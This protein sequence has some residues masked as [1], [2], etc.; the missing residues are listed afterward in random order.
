MNFGFLLYPGV[1]ELDFQGPWEIVGL[2]HKYAQGPRPV[3]LAATTAPVACAHGMRVLPDATLADAGPLR[4]LLVPGGF[5]AFELMKD[6]AT[7]DF[8]R[9]QAA[10]G[11]VLMSVCSGS[12][13][14]HAAGLLQGR[15]ASTNWKAVAMLREAGV[16]VDEERYTHDGPV[17]TSAG[18]SAGIDMLL[19]YIA[20][21]EGEATAAAVQLNAE[22]F[23]EGR[24]YCDPTSARPELPAYI[25]RLK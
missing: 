17:W 14:L 13:V 23:P 10:A 5:A 24:V 4:A 7:L 1:E 8:V 6:A 25:R 2:W 19:A 21:A 16:S 20:H 12:F 15:R 9:R 11:A 18:V 22:Y 3:L